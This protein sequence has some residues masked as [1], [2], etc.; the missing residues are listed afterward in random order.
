[1]KLQSGTMSK[2]KIE[3]NEFLL[4]ELQNGQERA[5]DFI[6]RKY[7]KSLCVQANSYVKDLDKAQSLVQDCFVKLWNN[8]NELEKVNR[9]A[10]YL[11][12]MVRNRCI[13]HLRKIKSIESLDKS[14]HMEESDI[15]TENTVNFHE[16]EERLIVALAVMPERSRMAFEYSRFEGLSYE[17]IADKMGITVKAVERLISR[18]LKSLRNDLKEYITVFILLCLSIF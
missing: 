13:D 2:L 14:E 4:L 8:R 5:F 16:F 1:M 6:F 10:P 3:N 9:L 7:Y 12:L 11:T 15:H 18:A 17:E